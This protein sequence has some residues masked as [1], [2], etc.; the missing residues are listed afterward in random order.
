MSTGR[1]PL[2]EAEAADRKRQRL[3]QVAVAGV[4]IALVAAIGIGIAVKRS[5]SDS[6]STAGPGTQGAP[7]SGQVT[8]SGAVRVGNPDAKV[9]IRVVADLQC[10]ACKAFEAANGQALE[11]AVADG[12][13]VVEYQII[14]FL[15]RA[16]T[17]QYSSRAANASFCVAETGVTHYQDWL[18][19][20]FAQQPAEGG[21][22]H[23]NAK[24]IQIAADA[25]YTDPAIADCVNSK[26]YDQ[27]IK[28]TTQATLNSGVQ[29]TPTVTV[30]GTQ[31]TDA[32][33]TQNGLAS[34][35][36]DAAK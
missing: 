10:P 26:K 9:K 36:A 16:S 13:A 14:S 27:Y 12:T 28:D 8:E 20:M 11:D 23:D 30:N 34:V 25:G 7:V 29:S 19:S 1:N 24:L 33:F 21:A 4:L 6:D 2:A 18:Q 15:D 5:G 3:I 22:G 32:L 17:N 31:V 35:I